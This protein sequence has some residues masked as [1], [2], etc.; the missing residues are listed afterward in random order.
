MVERDKRCFSSSVLIGLAFAGVAMW[1]SLSIFAHLYSHR[2]LG[3]HVW[4]T[5]GDTWDI[6]DAG[7]FVWHGALANV[8]D[9]ASSAYAL[10]LSF[11]LMAP[12]SA[13]VDHYHL[14]EGLVP[15]ARPNA[16]LLVGPFSLL[17]GIFLLDAVRRLAWDLGQRKLL[18]VSQLLAVGLV[19][20]PCFEWGHFEDVIA[21]TFV[22]H[23][24][25]YVMARDHVR[26][27]L[28]LSLAV[29]S[30]QWAV[31]LIPLLVLIAPR[32]LRLRCL[33]ASCALP[34]LFMGILLAFGGKTSFNAL[35][36]P[37]N[38]GREAPG[39]IS[40]YVTWLGSKTSQ[41]S[42]TLGVA[43]GLIVAWKLRKVST[44]AQILAAMSLMV[45]IRPFSEAIN[46]SY[47]WSPSLIL[48]GFV[49]VAAHGRIR[50]RDW[51]WQLAAV[52]WT[53]PHGN[54]AT[55]SWWWAGMMILLLCTWV[56]VA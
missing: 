19:L 34:A 49:G 20:V 3:H 43:V 27:G 50:L 46:Y 44:N 17:F 29:C 31:F 51:M 4:Y 42:R 48:A 25:R 32:G 22:L 37:V 18:W 54:P 55:Y 11:I 10:P 53:L 28:L 2:L 6:V 14:V 9:A 7:R 40:F 41:L 52:A 30:K 12:V 23:A 38:L 33:A 45:L 8:Y 56:Q 21:M 36:S 47:Y 24:A 16:W 39:H 1:Y 15:L 26:A 13:A 5:T 35:F